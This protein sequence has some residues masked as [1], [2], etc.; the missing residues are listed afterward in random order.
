M[1]ELLSCS[2]HQTEKIGEQLGVLLGEGDVVSL[3][4]SLG[5]G[6]TVFVH[7]I[8]RGL[9]VKDPVSSPSFIIVQE[10]K[11]RLPVF[12]A[13]FY[14]IKSLHELEEIGW[15]DYF[16]RRGV[17]L[18]EWG[19]LFSEA[20][21]LHYLRIEIERSEPI[22]TNRVIR[23]EPYGSRYEAIVEELAGKCGF[24]A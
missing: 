21:P 6:K 5:S 4:G 18:I 24:L 10:Y 22:E 7:G 23:F 13:D 12:H 11:G 19:D 3:N 14:R 1:L 20:L 9:G 2:P 16:E 17:M 15:C 8:A